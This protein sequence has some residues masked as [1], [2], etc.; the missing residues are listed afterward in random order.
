MARKRTAWWTRHRPLIHTDAGH[1]AITAEL[2]RLTLGG[3]GPAR[4]ELQVRQ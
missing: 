4:P 3:R 2:V 1:A